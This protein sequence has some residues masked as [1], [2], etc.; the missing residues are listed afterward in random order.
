MHVDYEGATRGDEG[1]ADTYIGAHTP[2]SIHTP[3]FLARAE[4]EDTSR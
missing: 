4:L 1:M 2:N 3:I